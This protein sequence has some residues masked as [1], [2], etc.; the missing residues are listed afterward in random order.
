MMPHGMAHE[1]QRNGSAST[2]M[3]VAPADGAGAQPRVVVVNH[4]ETARESLRR[5]CASVGLAVETYPTAEAFLEASDGPRPGCLLLELCLPGM[6]GL[7]LQRELIARRVG[8]PI[9]VVTGYGDVQAA[10][11]ALKAGAFDYFE[12]PFSRQLLLDRIHQAIDMDRA[13]WRTEAQRTDRARRLGCLTPRE[14]QVLDLVVEGKTN[15]EIA[16]TLAVHGKTVEC[17]RASLMRKLSVDSLA[18]MIRLVI[19]HEHDTR[20]RRS[21]FR[22]S[23]VILWV[24]AIIP[25]FTAGWLDDLVPDLPELVTGLV[26]SIGLV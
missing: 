7:A 18:E 24:L 1:W 3:Q 26:S 23:W 6:E 19:T 10:V 12:E 21:C 9:I 17:H 2:G 15:K 25:S 14:R 16:R 22:A 13:I 11:E 5:L 20:W 8:L 4:N